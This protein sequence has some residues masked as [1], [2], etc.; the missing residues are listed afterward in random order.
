[1]F[2]PSISFPQRICAEEQT[3][4]RDAEA[5]VLYTALLYYSLQCIFNAT[6]RKVKYILISGA[7]QPSDPRNHKFTKA[8]E[9][10]TRREE[11]AVPSCN[12]GASVRDS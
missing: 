11:K 1:M 4:K 3:F 7:R 5:F 8:G 6:E 12:P 2:I 10:C 9:N